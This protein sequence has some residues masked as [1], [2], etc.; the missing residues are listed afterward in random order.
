[1]LRLLVYETPSGKEHLTGES[2]YRK[3]L[4]RKTPGN[5]EKGPFCWATWFSWFLLDGVM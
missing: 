2:S 1:M 5:A 3:A 4:L